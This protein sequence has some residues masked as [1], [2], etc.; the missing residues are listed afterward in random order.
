MSEDTLGQRLKGYPSDPIKKGLEELLKLK[1]QDPYKFLARYFSHISY[2]SE[3]LFLSFQILTKTYPLDSELGE[4][5]MLLSRGSEKVSVKDVL[6][7]CS[8][9]QSCNRTNT[10]QKYLKSKTSLDFLD[11]KSIME[12]H[13]I[14]HDLEKVLNSIF[15]SK[16]VISGQ[17]FKNLL[18]KYS[19]NFGQ[20][21]KDSDK[22][23][24][25]Q[26]FDYIFSLT[27]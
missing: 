27:L 25:T 22:F 6:G 20:D 9:F 5:F 23:N 19:S 3:V 2:K 10:C 4:A 17:E 16:S 13:C 12:Y 21:L 7:L 11:F 8:F 1:P 24:Q 26:I 15:K 18:L 14:L